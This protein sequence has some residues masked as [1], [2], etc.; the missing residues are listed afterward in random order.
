MPE[1][2]P[3]WVPLMLV[4]LGLFYALAFM[5]MPFSVLG[6]K[7]RLDAIE[8][9]LDEI[10]DDIRALAARLPGGPGPLDFEDVYAAP[11]KPSARA[12]PSPFDRPPIP[13]AVRN[14]Y[15]DPDGYD[16]PIERPAPPPHLRPIRREAAV[17][18]PERVEPRLDRRR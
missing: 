7:P 5:V 15:D 12:E 9:R 4:V 13:P 17:V 16:G 3:W 1:W 14:M 11:V 10:Q 8:A 6:V 18:R 2:V